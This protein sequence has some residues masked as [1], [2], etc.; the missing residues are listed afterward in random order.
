MAADPKLKNKAIMAG[1]VAALAFLLAGA[2]WYMALTDKASSW[3][4]AQRQYRQARDKRIAETKLIAER[5][6]WNNAYETEREK[7]PSFPEDEQGVDT[8]WMNKMDTLAEENHIAI[9]QRQAG[10]EEQV[11]DV[12]ELPVDVKNWEGALE[13]LVKFMYGL[14]R[15]EG[16]MFDIRSIYM[17][18]SQHRGFLRGTFTLSCAYMR[19]DGE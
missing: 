3:N 14:E 18:P 19:G 15:A 4:K 8:H 10:K 7:M 9:A 17:K 16:A 2:L 12:Y 5:T 13:Y 1:V 11:G 6:K